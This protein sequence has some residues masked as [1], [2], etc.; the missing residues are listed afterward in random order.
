MEVLWTYFRSIWWNVGLSLFCTAFD[1]DFDIFQDV[2][3]ERPGY[4]LFK[5]N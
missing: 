5:F 1:F 2:S 3:K 4:A